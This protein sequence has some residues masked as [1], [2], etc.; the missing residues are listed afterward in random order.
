MYKF[1]SQHEELVAGMSTK[2][3]GNMKI[4]GTHS[5][6][7]ALKNRKAFCVKNNINYDKIVSARVE[8]TTNVAIVNDC[9]SEFVENT[10]A[11]V[12]SKKDIYLSVTSADCFPVLMYDDK[13]D[14]IGLAHAGWR[15]IV[16]EIVPQ[17]LKVMLKEGA[18]LSEIKVTIGPGISQD[19]FDFDLKYLIS[20]FGFYNQ[21]KYIKEGSTIDKVK[22]DLRKIIF[23]QSKN[24]GISQDNMHDCGKCTFAHEHDFFSA[25]RDGEDFAVMMSVF[26][27]KAM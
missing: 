19:Y 14:V 25:R 6:Q 18:E 8:H 2:P 1:F 3:D 5:T 23:D 13:N 20:E 15:G 17:T 22:V 24:I 26:G 7:Q 4:K 11:L 21:D 27:M 12:T 10:D 16:N 9:A